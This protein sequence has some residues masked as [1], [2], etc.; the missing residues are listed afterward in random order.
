MALT[1]TVS[2]YKDSVRAATTGANINLAAAPNTLD[3]VSLVLNDRVLVK[4]QTPSSLNGIYRVT[5]LGTGSN[6]VWTRASDFNDYRQITSGALTFVQQGTISGNIFYY[7]PGGEP[8]VQIGTTAITFSNLYSFIDNTVSQNLQSVT[9][10]GNT[11]T[12][13][14]TISNTT[15]ATSTTTG[16]L[17]VS[18]G[19]GIGG[20]LYV[21]GNL[22]V[23]GNTTFINT[24]TITTSD[25]I[26]APAINAGTIGNSGS[27]LVGLVNTN[28]QPY[29]TSVGT[30]TGLVSSGNISAQTANVYASNLIGNTAV[31]SSAYYWSNGATFAQTV[32]GTYSNSNVAAYLPTYTGTLSPNSLT[33]SN[34]G[35]I[36]GYLTGAIGAN[37]PNTGAFTTI[38]ATSTIVAQGTI[39][40]PTINAGT[41]G[42][43]GALL[44]GTLNSSSASQPNITSVGTL[45]SLTSSG[46]IAAPTVIGAII[47]NSGAQFYGTLNSQSSNQPNISSV[48]TL[49]SLTTSGNITA[50]TANVYASNI[51][52]NTAIYGAAFY[53]A[54][55]TPFSSS[56]YG[57]TQVGYYLN[58]NLITSTI[59]LPGNVIANAIYANSYLYANGNAFSSGSSGVTLTTS[60]TAPSSPTAG[61]QWYQ[62]NTDILYEYIKDATGASYWVDISTRAVVSNGAS[63]GAFTTLSVSGNTSL[64][65][66]ANIYIANG[67]A[68]QT[69]ALTIAGNIYG[70]GGSGYLDFLKLQNTYSSATNPNKFF[71]VNSTGGLEIINSAYTS[72]IFQL[73]DSGDATISGNLTVSGSSGITM[74]NRP[75]FRVTGNGGAISST[76]TVSGGYFVVDYNQGGYLNTSTGYFT[77]P[78]AGLYQV[79]IVVRTN[80]NTNSGINQIIIRKTTAIGSV[81][82]SQIMVEFG[83]NT[84]MNHTG[85]STVVKMAVGDTL[86]FDVTAGTI[87]FDGNDNWS[88]AYIG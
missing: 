5:T 40:S 78:V 48:G 83:A 63:A 79:N 44:Y 47:G 26:A 75:A 31:Y 62:G 88:V 53:F 50:Q 64:N 7:I 23:A 17:I 32:T 28:S 86:R 18:G 73:Q 34:G 46:T 65:N 76:T 80:S 39:S 87:S 72:T 35:Q 16:A 24:T 69:S 21:S 45:T 36:T 3:G 19:V 1:R 2:D 30:L 14:I 77:A 51:I 6:G 82:S 11:T 9:S 60:N 52:G 37:T 71:R 25:T 15:T 66:Y 67:S 8:N 68:G 12:Y 84:S 38:S 74:I 59:S 33:T 70:Q 43:S 4:D 27:N 57:N 56:S 54:N 55:G 10:Y 81:T 61:A 20:N 58:S 22:S 42:N 49:T 29:V 85:G 13:G 41:I